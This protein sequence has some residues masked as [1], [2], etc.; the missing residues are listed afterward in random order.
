VDLAKVLASNLI[1]L[2]HFA[3]YGPLSEA[4]H[5]STPALAGWLYDYARMAVQV[6]LVL[7][8]FLA[9][10]AWAP[11]GYLGARKPLRGIALRYLRLT[12]PFMA[13]MLI[14]VAAAALSR[15]VMAADFIPAAP[16][17]A[18]LLAHASL[19]HGVL[20]TE[21]LS[22]GVWYVAIDF[23]LFALLLVLLWL[24]AQRARLLVAAVA[25]TSLFFFNL[26]VDGDNW[27]LY[28]FGAYGL[29]AAA[30]WIGQAPKAGRW[31]MLMAVTL[32]AALAWEYR[33][34]ILL[35]GL[36]ALALAWMQWNTQRSAQKTKLPRWPILGLGLL[37]QASYALFLLHFS[38]LL[39]VNAWFA[40][41]GL[42]GSA[43]VWAVVGV[44]WLLCQFA[45]LAFE[46]WVE[47]PLARLRF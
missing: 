13:A 18:Q 34:R 36:V 32:A 27:A 14:T 12:P 39:L 17:L 24:G 25:L 16:T 45:A 7:G 21:S 30:W 19:L 11:D 35:A 15:S 42:V 44:S 41:A 8:G 23:Q 37:S 10:R 6:F 46:R 29:G 38:V 40:Y 22:V 20:G 26:H 9:A 33:T 2:H 5:A 1:V 3:T 43:A 4:L 31:V 47:R 28:F